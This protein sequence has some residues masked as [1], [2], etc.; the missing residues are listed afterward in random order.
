MRLSHWIKLT[1]LKHYK[2]I[3]VIIWIPYF[4]KKTSRN[5]YWKLCLKSLSSPK[6]FWQ[7]IYI[8]ISISICWNEENTSVCPHKRKFQFDV[9]YSGLS[10]KLFILYNK[11]DIII[12][13]TH[14]KQE[15]IK[16]F[17]KSCYRYLIFF[18]ILLRFSVY[19]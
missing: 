15:K 4:R 7:D 16:Y 8:Y 12:Q 2:N 18:L 11:I 9:I 5:W 10:N 1:P 6:S 13:L 14:C 17:S 3:V 19:P